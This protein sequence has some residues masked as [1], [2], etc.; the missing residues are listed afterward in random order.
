MAEIQ[1]FDGGTDAVLE[2]RGEG[3]NGAH[4]AVRLVPLD[5]SIPWWAL[6]GFLILLALVFTVRYWKSESTVA[7]VA[8]W[9]VAIVGAVVV[10]YVA[11]VSYAPVMFPWAPIVAV[12]SL[13]IDVGLP[14][15]L[16][17]PAAAKQRRIAYS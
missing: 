2:L 3:A 5:H 14:F 16:R 11:Y 9:T 10:D 13:V 15:L 8:V 4:V 7:R 17:R 1:K 6:W 12:I